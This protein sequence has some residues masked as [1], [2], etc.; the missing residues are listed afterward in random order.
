VIAD[1]YQEGNQEVIAVVEAN[2]T[3]PVGLALLSVSSGPA[4]SA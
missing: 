4:S 2:F 3:S 1:L